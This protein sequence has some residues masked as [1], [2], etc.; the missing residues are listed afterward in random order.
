MKKPF[1]KTPLMEVPLSAGRRGSLDFS[2][3]EGTELL[4]VYGLSPLNREIKEWLRR[5]QKRQL[6]LIEDRKKSPSSFCDRGEVERL[7]GN[8]QVQLIHLNE[9]NLERVIEEGLYR[10]S[11]C[12]VMPGKNRLFAH[13]LSDLKMN[14]EHRASLHRDYG[15]PFLKNVLENSLYPA[16]SGQLLEGRLNGIPAIICGAGPSLEKNLDLL[17][18]VEKKAVIFAG[19]SALDLLTKRQ[20]P[21]DFGGCIDPSHRL[22]PCESPLF[23]QN[24]TNPAS[25]T[26]A[27]GPLIRMGPSGGFPLERWLIPKLKPFDAGTHVGTF[28]TR[29]ALFLGCNPIVF[30]GMDGC[31]SG[32]RVYFDQKED[33]KRRDSIETSDRFGHPVFS[34]PDFLLGRRF[35]EHLA[36][37]NLSTLFLNATEGGLSMEGIV[38][39][40][41][42]EVKKLY[43]L[44]KVDTSSLLQGAS[45]CPLRPKIAPLFK[46]FSACCKLLERSCSKL[47]EQAKEQVQP[48]FEEAFFEE[49]FYQFVLLPNWRV[50]RFLLQKKEIVAQM[51]DPTFEKWVQQL[52]FFQ[53]VC[54][55]YVPFLQR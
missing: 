37:E 8:P 12:L 25:L 48:R 3:Q 10:P 20:V 36:R 40:E 1:E 29:V 41:L 22:T 7:L 42:K 24:Q 4:Y 13:H 19:G 46:S 11:E 51:I 2:P 14:A 18:R 16:F 50:W 33:P 15:V 53:T 54:Q 34:R 38:E 31:T 5:D 44:K 39:K 28:L 21:I 26:Q 6:I 27:K 52:V 32:G 9:K 17:K 35:F 55:N 49:P 47:L 45:V 30:V 43:F 23:F